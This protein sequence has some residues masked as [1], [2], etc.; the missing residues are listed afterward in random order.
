MGPLKSY[1]GTVPW[2]WRASH[3]IAR[4]PRRQR[5]VHAEAATAGEPERSVRCQLQQPNQPRGDSEFRYRHVASEGGARGRR[6]ADRVVPPHSITGQLLGSRRFGSA[7]GPSRRRQSNARAG[8]EL[9]GGAGPKCASSRRLRQHWW[10]KR[11]LHESFVPIHA[12][13]RVCSD[14]ASDC[15]KRLQWHAEHLLQGVLARSAGMLGPNPSRS[16]QPA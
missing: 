5:R 3:R 8:C 15:E 14:L 9:G 13:G 4:S 16:P 11:R 12:R 1:H 6:V 10:A 2:Y 7:I